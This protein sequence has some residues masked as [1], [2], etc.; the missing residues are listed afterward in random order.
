MFLRQTGRM[1][2][3]AQALDALAREDPEAADE[4]KAALGWLTNG[5]GLETV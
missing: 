4:A 2:T 5:A 3:E 1:M